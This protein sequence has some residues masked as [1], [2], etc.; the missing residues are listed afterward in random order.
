MAIL[1]STAKPTTNQ[2]AW[3][4]NSKNQFASLVTLPAGGPWRIYQVGVW[5]GG[6]NASPTCR[7]AIW[8]SG[9]SYL[10]GSATFAAA[11]HGDL[12]LGDATLYV[13]PLTSDQ[14]VAG[15]T[16]IYVGFVRDGAEGIQ[17]PVTGSG[18]HIEVATSSEPTS[19]SG[20]STHSGTLG[21]Y[22]YYEASNS[23]PLA[24]TI[25]GPKGG[26]TLVDTTPTLLFYA[27]DPDDD[28]IASYDLQVSTDS[29]FSSVTHWNA[30]NQGGGISGQSVSRV[31]AGSALPRGVS[32][33]WRART[34]DGTGD[35][36]WSAVAGFHINRIPTV[37]RT[38]PPSAGLAVIHN[39]STD[40]AVW[41]QTGTFARPRFKWTFTDLDG[42]AQNAFQVRIYAASSG[43]T[44]L[45]DS[46][47]VYSSAKQYDADW[48]GVYGT[49]YWWEVNVRDAY[50]E[51]SGVS[52][53]RWAFRMKFGQAIYEHA[54]PGG[55]S[56]SSWA[57]GYNFTG[58]GQLGFLYASATGAN[59]VGRSAW[60][61]S[62]GQV[63]PNNYLNI[64][65]R[66]G[67]S[68]VGATMALSD[69]TFS[70]LAASIQP[71]RWTFGTVS[72]DWVLDPEQRRYGSQSLRMT[73][74]TGLGDRIA[75]PFTK[76]PDDDFLVSPN[77]EYTASVYVKTDAPLVSG[78]RLEVR[79]KGGMV[80]WIGSEI[81]DASHNLATDTSSSPEGWQRIWV[82]FR[83]DDVD[84]LRLVVV[85]DVTG[86]VVGDKFWIDAIQLEESPIPSPWR[87]GMVG[88]P[89]VLDVN[90]IAVDGSQGGIFRV[91][92]SDGTSIA[93]LLSNGLVGAVT[94]TFA[95][96]DLLY[97]DVHL[98]TT[99][100]ISTT[101]GVDSGIHT[102]QFVAAWPGN[103]AM[104]G[105]NVLIRAYLIFAASYNVTGEVNISLMSS[106]TPNGSGDGRLVFTRDRVDSAGAW[107][108]QNA[109][110]IV[111]YPAATAVN[112]TAQ[113]R[114]AASATV[115]PYAAAATY[116][117][118]IGYHV[119]GY[120]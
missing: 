61:T 111:A 45:H 49:E 58:T 10:R 94:Q 98:T 17:F 24:P 27:N 113:V 80:P 65:V 60:K 52:S 20:F 25:S 44:P 106:V 86:S 33:Y 46:G 104:T 51:W 115:T 67:A 54:V 12:T 75:Y 22:L 70:Y 59:G 16:S 41:A 6:W 116:V 83:T 13:K 100:T 90:G 69:M 93:E 101:G 53:P 40:T 23:L 97:K 82:R 57:F 92:G 91:R 73:R 107:L 36:P 78:V 5:M 114:T 89:V 35:G 63:T 119:L 117:S 112:F 18:T 38:A 30:L 43:G 26:Q 74:S 84:G 108:T 81:I 79:G 95:S 110:R 11:N 76:L 19:M 66:E 87:P 39:L 15:G 21:A 32:I 1:G 55:P 88:N 71:E 109:E 103:P 56:S 2:E 50:N 62:I 77:T 99:S 64:L 68:V 9:G 85:Q 120:D 7:V 34:N 102:S 3:G 14:I 4:L 105:K 8:N 31:Y 48:E 47:Y 28:P 118:R 42:D 29:D 37:T 72:P 96:T